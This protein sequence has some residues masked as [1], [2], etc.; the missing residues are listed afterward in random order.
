MKQSDR[1]TKQ[2][3]NITFLAE[4]IILIDAFTAISYLK[5]LSINNVVFVPFMIG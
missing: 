4:I 3:Q 2:Y 1:P 5:L